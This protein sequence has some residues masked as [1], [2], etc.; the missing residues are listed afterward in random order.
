MSHWE[1]MIARLANA[2]SPD[3]V[4]IPVED[5]DEDDN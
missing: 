5:D 3:D 2:D 1:A 4:L